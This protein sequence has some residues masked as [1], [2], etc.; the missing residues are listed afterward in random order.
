MAQGYF[1]S[2][3]P[4]RE[5]SFSVTF[6]ENP[7]EGG[8]TVAAGIGPAL[9]FLE[10]FKFTKKDIAYLRSLK[11]AD[12]TLLFREDFF[13]HLLAMKFTCDVE[14]VKEGE[15]V[16][17]N[18]PII[19]ITGPIDQC[20]L[21][22]TALLNIINF[23]SLIATKASR[24]CYAADGGE[25]LEF[26]LRRAQGPDGGVTASR[27]SYIGGC[28]ATSNVLAG[29]VF[30][31]PVAGTHAHSWIMAFDSEEEAFEVYAE[32]SPNNVILLV[33]TYDTLEGVKKAIAVGLDM[34]S[35]GQ[36]FL[37]IRLDSGDLAWLSKKAREM[38]DD[39]GLTEAKIVASN[40]LD[41]HTILSLI[42]QGA[43]I[44]VWGVGTKLA[45]AADHSALSGVYKLSAVRSSADEPWQPRMKISDQA[46][47]MSIPGVLRVRRYFNEDD[48]FAGDMIYDIGTSFSN[49]GEEYDCGCEDKN[50]IT[51]IDPHDITRRK[52]FCA[53][54]RYV[55]LLVPMLEKGK[56]VYSPP[57]I[58]DVR[59]YA[60]KGLEAL[61]ETQ[62]RFLNP[63]TYPVGLE[64]N[65]A[66]FR[67]DLV[68]A[69]RSRMS[70]EGN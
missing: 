8:Y 56:R 64:K 66:K 6:R 10:K 48:T 19:S 7:F 67:L 40:A 5:A 2:G 17:P 44:D 65:L 58:E 29:Q 28:V 59:A 52:S 39:A 61:D 34:K 3:R 22:E 38:L 9:D 53:K 4:L 20:Q 13:E 63:Y 60:L 26:G 51:M 27:A 62:R 24:C 12:G 55:E 31:I 49:Y 35:K 47:K 42:Q 57:P 32:T 33:D 21:V 1:L 54:T 45:T 46:D 25:I 43:M 68:S 30:G 11:A 37:G 23:S 15:I 14:A 41:E 70:Q 36:N 50:P 18:E 16:F 69:S